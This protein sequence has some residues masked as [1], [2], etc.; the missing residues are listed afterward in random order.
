MLSVKFL[1]LIKTIEAGDLSNLE[2]FFLSYKEM[3]FLDLN[4]LEDFNEIRDNREKCY[5]LTLS[6]LLDSLSSYRGTGDKL[7]RFNE[8]SE[9]I[10]YSDKLGIFIEVKKIP[11]RFKIIAVLHLDGMQKGLRG[12]IFEFIRFF[13]KY[14]LFEMKFN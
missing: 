12:R 6:K 14:N 1:E 8:F 7:T 11:F 13:N 5:Y 3:N 9:L 10:N 2:D 4:D